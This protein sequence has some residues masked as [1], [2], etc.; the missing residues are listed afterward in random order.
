MKPQELISS[1]IIESYVL[2]LTNDE[3]TQLV[4]NMAIVHENIAQEIR[5]VEAAVLAYSSGISPALNRQLKNKIFNEINAGINT[6]TKRIPVVRSSYK[7]LAIACAI[8]LFVCLSVLIWAMYNNNNTA[9]QLAK[10]ETEKDKLNKLSQ[11]QTTEIK[12]LQDQLSIVTSSD[13]RVVSLKNIQSNS[14]ES[15]RIYWQLSTKDVFI[16]MNNTIQLPANSQFQLWAIIDGKPINAGL[17]D[18]GKGNLQK[19]ENIK[20]AQTFAITIEKIGG[21]L[22][23]TLSQMIAMANV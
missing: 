8:G 17:I 21:S 13:T 11:T 16:Q 9:Q 18:F 23:P 10:T 4:N 12:G 19:M 2:G 5:D 20:S 6:E 3:E 22:Q 1:G 15:A 7:Q 14:V